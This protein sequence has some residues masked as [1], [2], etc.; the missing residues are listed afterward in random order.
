MASPASSLRRQYLGW[1]NDSSSA[2]GP[3]KW[4]HHRRLQHPRSGSAFGLRKCLGLVA[5]AAISLLIFRI[6]FQSRNFPA[7]DKK[8]S[9]LPIIHANQDF[10]G[11]TMHVAR[12][13]QVGQVFLGS[14]VI[15]RGVG[16]TTELWSISN[17]AGK[18]SQN[19][20][21]S[22]NVEAGQN[23]QPSPTGGSS[24]LWLLAH[25]GVTKSFWP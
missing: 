20:A 16:E 6:I 9:P 15:N 4:G 18:E 1:Q 21:I 2:E 12:Q 3:E 19:I 25:A 13:I 22:S 8:I 24:G 11:D 23:F 10:T 5:L 17:P 7:G 14:G